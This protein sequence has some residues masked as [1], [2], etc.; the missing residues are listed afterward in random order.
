MEPR[1]ATASVTYNGSN[2][3]TKLA[4]FLQSLSYTDVASGESDTLSLG[5]N[6][7]ERKWIK[8]W[9]P[10]KGDTMEASILLNNWGGDGD[11]R[12]MVCGS[13][14]IDNFSFSGT[15]IKLKLDA[16]AIPADSSF[17]ETQRTKTYE[18]TTLENI[19]QEIA[20][21]AGIS[22]Y[23]EAPEVSIEK[24]EQSEKDDC[25][26]YNELVKTYGFAM[27]IYKSKIV[28]FNEATYEQRGSVTTL[29]ESDIEPNWSWN[30]KLQKTYT[31]AK[32]EYTNNDKNTTFTVNVGE[33]DRI[34]KVT[35]AA[36][37]LAEAERIT[38]AK[39]NEANK[40][41]TTMSL[42]VSQANPSIIATSCVNIKGLGRIDGKYY[43]NKVTWSVGGGVLKQKLDL[44][45]VSERFTE[46]N[47]QEEAVATESETETNTI[48][49]TSDGA[50]EEAG[51]EEAAEPAIG[52]TYTLTTTKKGYYTAAEALADNAI[53][54]HPTGIRRPDTYY[55]FN[56][57][58]GMYNL[59]T[60]ADVP[61]SWV[62]PN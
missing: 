58:Q 4:A 55:I 7:R 50:D 23:Y 40:D 1:S 36:S 26:F 20:D 18:N 54:G 39:L 8:S 10:T 2:I 3:D 53:G 57:S 14:V 44:R 42:T 56:I 38:L 25:S 31:G 12:I 9:F 61:G 48:T 13:F 5:I 6:D 22:L 59:T 35:D 41:D 37:T 62:N 32:Y 27:K 49:E 24:I 15:P 43:A 34:L 45:R 21:R 46:V 11:T 51:D 16:V 47:S 28:V 17:K 29:T 60:K 33:G 52:D 30:T 19:G